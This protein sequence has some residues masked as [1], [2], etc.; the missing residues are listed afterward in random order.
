MA[1]SET[2][3]IVTADTLP[4]LVFTLRNSN[5]AASGMVLDENDETTWAPIDITSAVVRMRI[6]EVGETTLVDTRTGSVVDGAAGTVAIDFAS[7]TFA[8]A[9][10]YEGEIE[11]TFSSGG[12]Q[13][14]VDL[15]KFKVRE[16]FG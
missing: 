12:V 8:T 5:L 10:T 1:Y 2:I 9:G 11:I 13:T 3:E 14:L 7:T 6:R 4:S 15:V 16:G